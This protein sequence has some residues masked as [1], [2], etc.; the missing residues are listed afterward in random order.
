MCDSCKCDLKEPF[1]CCA[2]CIQNLCL[3]CFSNGAENSTHKNTHSYIIRDD[4]INIFTTSTWTANEEKRLLDLILKHG[5]ANWDDISKDMHTKNSLECK[6]HYFNNYF[7]GIFEKTLGLTLNTYDREFVPHLY[8]LKC[9]VPPRY[10]LDSCNFKKISGYRCARGDFDNPYDPSAESIFNIDYLGDDCRSENL[11]DSNLTEELKCAVF[12]VY[13]NRLIERH[14]R[15]KIMKKYG[16]LMTGKAFSWMSKH[17]EALGGNNNVGRFGGAGKFVALM[18]LVPAITFDIIVEAI[19][20]AY[21]LKQMY[22]KL[23]E[24]RK[25]GITT[26]NGAQ[27]YYKYNSKRQSKIRDKRI[28]QFESKIDWRMKFTDQ[29]YTALQNQILMSNALTG[30]V[31][32]RKAAPL[33]IIGLPG[34]EK[35]TEDEKGLCSS[36]RIFPAAYIEYRNILI[37]ENSKNGYLRLADARRLIKIDVNKTRQMY[38]FLLK[39]GFINKSII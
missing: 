24:L 31:P 4:K 15:Y 30:A 32:R 6:E 36:V 5:F 34:Y 13:N 3:S 8:K 20:H 12:R 11:I 10:D 1:I 21:D 25:I 39:H 9:I 16:L 14:R 33:Q 18:Q 17:A 23:T 29:T 2:E 7:G 28:S 26:F 19:Q 27:I 35:L 38:D 37:N 22:F